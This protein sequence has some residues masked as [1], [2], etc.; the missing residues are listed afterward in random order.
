MTHARTLRV[1]IGDDHR[2]VREG[3]SRCWSRPKK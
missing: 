1:L 3:L 2:I